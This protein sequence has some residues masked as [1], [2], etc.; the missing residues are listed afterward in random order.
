VEEAASLING[1]AEIEVSGNI[2]REKIMKLRHLPI[3]YISMGF[4]TYAAG[5]ADFSL[6]LEI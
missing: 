6:T 5:H 4:I 3:D 1:C 2:N